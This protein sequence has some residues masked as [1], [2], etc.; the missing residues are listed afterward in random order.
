MRYWLICQRQAKPS[1]ARHHPPRIQRI[2]HGV[3]RMK[4]VL[5]AV[6]CMPLLG[7]LYYKT[8]GRKTDATQQ[9]LKAWVV[10]QRVETWV[11]F[12]V[13]NIVRTIFISLVQFGK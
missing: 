4:A 10:A 7:A 8:S 11:N 1:N 9:I 6:G 3:S 5:F 2:K 12:D 13:D